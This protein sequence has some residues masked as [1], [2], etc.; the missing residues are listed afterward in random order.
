MK[1]KVWM[2]NEATCLKKVNMLIKE[3][4]QECKNRIGM[5]SNSLAL[6]TIL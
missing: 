4:K 5:T 1:T 3:S 2:S 6:K